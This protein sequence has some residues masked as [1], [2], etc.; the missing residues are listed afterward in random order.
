[1]LGDLA[2]ASN[3]DV[4]ITDS[5]QPVLY[6]LRSGTDTLQK[7][8]HPLFRS[9]QGVAPTADGQSLYVADYSHGLLRVDVRTGEVSR[10]MDAPGS[11]SLGCD[12]ISLSGNTIIAVQNG[13]VPAQIMRYEIDPIA[14]RI[15]RAVVIDRNL[16]LAP[17]PTI[18]T[19][20]GGEFVYVANSLWEE[21]D[22]NGVLKAGAML[23]KPR[24]LSVEWIV[25]V[26][27]DNRLELV[28]GA[29]DGRVRGR[30]VKGW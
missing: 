18:G 21:F 23:T 22:D 3:G 9:L 30:L 19:I 11:T 20:V 24:L 5:T 16:E 27:P 15:I 4:F 13:V 2:V 26:T 10:L 28:R 1:V 17:E 12:G 6:R 7:Y 25:R 29:A 8:T 14:L